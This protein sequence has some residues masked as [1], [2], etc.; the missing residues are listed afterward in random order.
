LIDAY[1]WLSW[2]SFLEG[3]SAGIKILQ[4]IIS[5]VLPP[6]LL[7]VLNLLLPIVLRSGSILFRVFAVS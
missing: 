2:L 6:V 3:D 4:G 5:G 7:A 1:P